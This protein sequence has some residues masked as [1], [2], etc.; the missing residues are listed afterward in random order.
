[1]SSIAGMRGLS[2]H[3][4][5][6]A[7]GKR[8]SKTTPRD[9]LHQVGRA[10]PCPPQ[11]DNNVWGALNGQSGAHPSCV[12][13]L[14]RVHG[15]RAPPNEKRK[16]KNGKQKSGRG[17]HE[18][19]TFYNDCQNKI[20]NRDRLWPLSPREERAGRETERGAWEL[21]TSSPQSS[22][23]SGVGRRASGSVG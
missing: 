11:N 16:A 9:P 15:V 18:A 6:A 12:P 21:K 22:P 5:K 4:Q 13:A 7:N 1:M 8:K 10:V 3:K 20:P 14:W 19:Q 17:D 2:G 23:P